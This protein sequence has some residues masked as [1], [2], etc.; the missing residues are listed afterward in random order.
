M[1]PSTINSA[2]Q[3]KSQDFQSTLFRSVDTTESGTNGSE[4]KTFKTHLP[5]L[6]VTAQIYLDLIS[7][8]SEINVQTTS[9]QHFLGHKKELQYRY[10]SELLLPSLLQAFLLNSQV[11][12]LPTPT[13][14]QQL[15]QPAFI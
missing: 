5:S 10:Q 2:S 8:K 12:V 13:S 1:E 11:A 4:M 7:Y 6:K 15:D 14:K 3:L 9:Q